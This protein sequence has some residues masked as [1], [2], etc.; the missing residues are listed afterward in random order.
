M[1]WNVNIVSQ[2]IQENMDLGDF[3]IVN[4]LMDFQQNLKEAKLIRKFQ[5]L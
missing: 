5:K 3:V 2:D 1:K 4:V